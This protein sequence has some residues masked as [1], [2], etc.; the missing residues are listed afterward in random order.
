MPSGQSF[1]GRV[2]KVTIA[3]PVADKSNFK[4]TISSTVTEIENLRVQFTVKKTLK[5]EPN[6]SEIKITNLAPSTRKSLQTKG[7]KVMLQAG[8]KNTG[9]AKIFSGDARAIDHVRT[10]ADWETVLHLGDGERSWQFATVNESFSPGASKGVVMR[11]L[12]NSL[13]VDVGNAFTVADSLQGSLDGGWCASGSAA[14]EFG[15]LMKA[16][17]L[18]WS[19][20]DGAI[21][22]L[23]PYEAL[24]SEIEE[25]S[26]SSG[27]IGSPEMGTPGKKGKPALLEFTTLLAPC[28]VGQKVRLKS[29]RYDGEVRI[30]AVEFTGDTASGDWYRKIHGEVIK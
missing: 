20:Q 27:L 12:A 3:A 24:K 2:C 26:P 4:D 8:Y 14:R 1:F 13:G 25:I 6:T 17:G 9:M 18:E 11:T 21:Q 23:K 10:G 30:V 28:K 5:K 7:V 22:V 19:I 29:E 16:Y 15:R